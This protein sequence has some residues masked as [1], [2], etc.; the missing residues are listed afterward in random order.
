MALSLLI[1]QIATLI[2]LVWYT[3]ETHLLRSSAKTFQSSERRIDYYFSVDYHDPPTATDRIRV[4]DGSAPKQADAVATVSNL[5][6]LALLIFGIKVK[7]GPTG[8][9]EYRRTWLPVPS[10]DIQQFIVAD[11]IV[12]A[13]AK[14]GHINLAA[15][16][17][18]IRWSGEIEIAL[19]FYCRGAH[20]ISGWHRHFIEIDHGAIKSC[21]RIDDGQKKIVPRIAKSALERG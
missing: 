19:L 17:E 20:R 3:V 9:W 14:A 12:D 6:R 2:A 15:P 8:E 13:M 21:H 11:W 5:G 18:R 10:G 16:P 1:V 4:F 7:A